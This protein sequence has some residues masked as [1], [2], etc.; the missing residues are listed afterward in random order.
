MSFTQDPSFSN[1]IIYRRFQ[2]YNN[3]NNTAHPTGEVASILF[4]ILNTN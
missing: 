1:A 4:S 3:D 2:I